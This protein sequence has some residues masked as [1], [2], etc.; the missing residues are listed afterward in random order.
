MQKLK[1][2]YNTKRD[3]VFKSRLS[4]IKGVIFPG[5]GK[6]FEK[7]KAKSRKLEGIP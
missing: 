7:Q 1:S 2:I 6:D 5:E 4:I 3:N